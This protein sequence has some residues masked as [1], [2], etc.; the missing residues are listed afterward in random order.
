MAYMNFKRSLSLPVVLQIAFCVAITVSAGLW[1]GPT[2]S[3]ERPQPS[4]ANDAAFVG[5]AACAQCHTSEHEQWT[6]SQHA[7]A[8]QEANDQTVLGK[9]DGT[10]FTEDG[11]VSTFFKKDG[12]Y[13]I[14]TDGPDGKLA[15]FKV[16]Y[17]FG[18]APL[19]QYLIELPGGRLQA[20]GVAWDSRPQS[21]G[22]QRWYHLYP[23]SKLKAGN[24]L[25]WTGIDQ[26]WNYQCAW[27]HSTN[28]KKNFNPATD[29]F[30]TSWSEIHVGCEACHGPGSKHLAWAK[31]SDQSKDPSM[32]L[33][34]EFNERHGVTWSVN[35]DG[36]PVRS[37][38]RTTSI[39]IKACASCHARRGQYDDDPHAAAGL[40]DAFRPSLLDTGL[41]YVDGQQRDEVYNFA[42]FLQ[43]KMYA[44]GVTCS[45]CHNPHTGKIRA[46]GNAVCAQCHTPERYDTPEHHHHTP[47]SDGAQCASCH[48]PTTTYM[49]VDPRHDHSIRIPRPDRT[50]LLGT[51]NACNQCHKDKSASWASEAIKT[52]YP[53][54]IPGAQDFAEAFSRADLAAPGAQIALSRIATNASESA[55]ARASAVARLGRFPSRETMAIAA[56]SLKS[57]DVLVKAAA[58]S[59]IA[60]ADAETR[61]AL[62]VPLLNDKARLVRMDAARALV[63]QPEASLPAE[64]GQ[65]FTAAIE[66]YVAAQNFNA[67]RPESHVNLGTLYR[68]QGKM[69]DAKAQF[70]RAISI[71]PTFVAGSLALADLVRAGGDEAKSEKILR[72]ALVLNPDA[73]AVQ[74]ALGLSLVRQ[75]RTEEGVTWL[76]KAAESTPQDPHITYVLGVALHDTGKQAEAIAVLKNALARHPYDR[77]ILIGLA[78]Y[79]IERKD[80]SSALTYANTLAELEPNSQEVGNMVTWLR[81]Q[82][83]GAN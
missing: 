27:C 36:K 23:G 41:Y 34:P 51:P 2:N 67:E 66:E 22:G 44:A 47:K 57:D 26:N 5:S 52:W 58:I 15:D 73:G 13:W 14:N 71:D 60:T 33:Y 74:Y 62:L 76:R 72:D 7:H 39:E 21:E 18:I 8:M 49:G 37:T 53:K 20:F 12:A 28:L 3:Q 54:P 29:E 83:S 42:S 31:T 59:I 75:K 78:S 43:S 38:P 24:P 50:T 19:Q 48:M 63:G 35:A 82:I 9:F 81:K 6:S 45:D 11:V 64:A 80:Y 25:H 1:A 77:E 55:I 61:V 65:A 30:K 79:A 56:Q 70:E 17:T 10:T 4:G 69:E 46:E 68:D 16:R 40:Y 32:G